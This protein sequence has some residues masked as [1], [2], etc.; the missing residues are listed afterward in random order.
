LA[1]LAFAAYEELGAEQLHSRLRSELRAEGLAM[2]PRRSQPR[3]THGWG[4]LTPSELTIVE[5]TGEGLTNTE[6]AERLFVSRRTVESH[7]G[8]VYDKLDLSTRAQLVASVVRRPA[9]DG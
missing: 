4:S 9:G 1:K 8:R 3:P 2:R 6:I 7:L 5:L